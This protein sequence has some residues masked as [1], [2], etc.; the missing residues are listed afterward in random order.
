MFKNI[1]K[2][3]SS[4]ISSLVGIFLCDFFHNKRSLKGYKGQTG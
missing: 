3:L 2:I 1:K 4:G